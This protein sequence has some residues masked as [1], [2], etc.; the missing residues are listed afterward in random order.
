MVLYNPKEQRKYLWDGTQTTDQVSHPGCPLEA[1][2][3]IQMEEMSNG[4]G[5]WGGFATWFLTT[6]LFPFCAPA[7]PVF[8]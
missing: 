6:H 3:T 1:D 5:S 7:T 8:S 2:V 4:G